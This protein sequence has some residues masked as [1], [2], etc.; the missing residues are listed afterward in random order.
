MVFPRNAAAPWDEGLEAVAAAFGARPREVWRA[1]EIVA[2]FGSEA[3]VRAL[4]P[5]LAAIAALD[6]YGVLATAPG[7]DSDFVSRFFVPRMGIPEDPVTGATHCTLIPLWG[8]KLR[9]DRLF[10]RQVS[11]RG[12]ELRCED[13]GDRVA[14]TGHAVTV[15]EGTMVVPG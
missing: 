14:I 2:V 3:E 5:D 7:D 9:K 11:A 13:L 10:A 12:G 1:R 15:L 6:A 4:A 8:A